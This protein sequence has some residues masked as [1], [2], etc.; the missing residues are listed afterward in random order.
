LD[1]NDIWGLMTLG[2]IYEQKGMYQEALA[3]QRR[4]WDSSIR[5]ASLAHVFARSGDRPAAE[6]ILADLLAQSKSKYVSSYD[7][8]VAYSGLDDT[9]QTFD[10]LNRAY[11]EHAGYLLFLGSDPRFKPIRS[12]RRFQDLLR[13]MRFPN[14]RV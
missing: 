10:W 13:R 9:P 4:S 7:I 1:P 14:Q 12:D 5:N 11:E 2:W 3:S 6:K 8:A